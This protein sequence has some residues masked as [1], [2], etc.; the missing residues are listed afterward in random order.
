M[1][2]TPWP[3]TPAALA[4]AV[5]A[6]RLA[7]GEDA[8]E[9]DPFKD[10]EIDTELKRLGPTVAAHVE[11]YAS[12]APLAVRDEAVVRGVAW[13]RETRG[14]ARFVSATSNLTMQP[15][16]TSSAA[17]FRNSGSAALLKPWRTR[18]AGVAG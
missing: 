6:L 4:T 14:A 3:E 2:L 10:D 11:Q 5:A 15:S 9:S 7:L 1:A 17:W 12:G 8:N 16:P 18:R 13:L